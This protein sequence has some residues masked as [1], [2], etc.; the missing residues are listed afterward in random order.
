MKVGVLMVAV[1]L[2][3]WLGEPRRWHPLV[4]FG[5][6]AH[7]LE[8]RLNPPRERTALAPD[9]LSWEHALGVLAVLLAV[10]PPV[11]AV[12]MLL[13][14]RPF[15]PLMAVVILYLVIGHRSLH[16]HAVAV[17]RAL[18]KEDLLEARRRVGF[19]VSRDTADMDC[20]RIA[21]A[22]VE[23][24][25]E[26]GNDALFGALFW[27]L[28]SGAAGAL[29]YRLI[30]TLDAMW[31]Y[32]T[33]RYR[34]FGWAAARLDDLMNF[35]PARLTALSYA[36]VGH[37]ATALRCWRLQAPA[38]DSPNAG[39]VMACGAGALQIRVGGGAFYHGRWHSRS[40]LG[41]GRAADRGDIRRAQYLVLRALVLW[42]GVAT[43]IG[44]IGR[45]L[46][47]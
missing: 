27:F 25:L 44:L 1:L 46:G 17:D 30:N 2:D 32:R 33:E 40:I 10:G 11:L 29:A 31:G 35:L 3:G 21:G 38:W 6:L 37:V 39:P 47:A 7:H 34:Q 45:A 13:R 28:V 15:A 24:V 23:S 20:G 43:L 5:N 22:T 42:I 18:R 14:Y 12:A 9:R 8:A 41:E 16:E 26:N 19:M 4:G 36:A